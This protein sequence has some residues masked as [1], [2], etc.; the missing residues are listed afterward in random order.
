MDTENSMK[1]ARPAF[2]FFK[3]QPQNETRGRTAIK[4]FRQ[5]VLWIPNSLINELSNLREKPGRCV[6]LDALLSRLPSLVP[7]PGVSTCIPSDDQMTLG[8]KTPSS[9]SKDL[10][11]LLSMEFTPGGKARKKCWLSL[12]FDGLHQDFTTKQT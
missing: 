3:A 7:T 9:L 1:Q 10:L 8:I 5:L 12:S 2:L 4:V 11:P 6:L